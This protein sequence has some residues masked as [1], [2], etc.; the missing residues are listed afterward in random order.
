MWLQNSPNGRLAGYLAQASEPPICYTDRLGGGGGGADYVL[1]LKWTILRWPHPPYMLLSWFFLPHPCNSLSFPSSTLPPT[2]TPRLL[3]YHNHWSPNQRLG[4]TGTPQIKVCWCK[5]RRRTR[6]C[7]EIAFKW[8]TLPLFIDV[9][10][11]AQV[12][13]RGTEGLEK[14]SSW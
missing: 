14:L 1:L 6:Y 7:K 2:C 10:S 13:L 11:T 9:L 8:F 4:R 12:S 5:C 3:Q